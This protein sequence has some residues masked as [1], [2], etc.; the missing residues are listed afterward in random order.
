MRKNLIWKFLFFLSLCPFI[1]PF[2]YYVLQHLVHNHYSW[3]LL[4]MLI[5]WS[6]VYW[7]TYLIG[8]ILLAIS[9]YKLKKGK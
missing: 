7:P 9:T 2:F 6:F 1:A 4:D 3:T 5:L 8:L